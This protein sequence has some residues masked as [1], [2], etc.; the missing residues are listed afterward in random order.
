ML[1]GYVAGLLAT[2]AGRST[3]APIVVVGLAALIAEGTFVLVGALLGDVRVTWLAMAHGVPSS[4]LY[5]V[6]LTPFV[7]PLVGAV[8][9]RL[10]PEPSVR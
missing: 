2:E 7:V 9:R 1:A 10:D 8:V 4:V 5:D 3:L 6:V